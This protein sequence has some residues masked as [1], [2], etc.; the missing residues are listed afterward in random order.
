MPGEPSKTKRLWGPLEASVLQGDGIDI[1]CG[2]DPVFPDVERFDCEQ[3]DANHIGRYVDRQ[4]DF[5]YASHCLEHM[6]D[7]RAAITQWWALVRPGG[8]LF[9]IVPDEDLYEQG[10]C[11]SRFN[12][13]HKWTFTI[14]KHSSWSP[15]SI[16]LLDLARSLPDSEMLDIR[17]QDSQ[18]Q[19]YLLSNGYRFGSAM[20]RIKVAVSRALY[21]VL[22]GV[23]LDRGVLKRHLI[24]PTDQTS[25][26]DTL[27][28]IQCIVRKHGKAAR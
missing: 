24:H 28:Q 7:A 27:A 12:A 18:Y 16:N 9:L 10:F 14:A 21:V 15:V 13:D 5:V 23:G 2:D 8:V 1:G 22:R 17:L 19:R 20:Y 25:Y 26:P 3:G 11:P 6:I 4:F